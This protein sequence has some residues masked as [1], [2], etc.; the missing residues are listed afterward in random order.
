MAKSRKDYYEENKEKELKRQ[1]E[2]NEKHK[3]SIK[4]YYQINKEELKRKKREYYLKNKEKIISLQ[5]EYNQKNKEH[6][7]EYKK[8]YN[9]AYF[10]NSETST[11]SNDKDYQKNY[12]EKNKERQ[13]EY[14]KIYR[15]NNKEKRN[16]YQRERILTDPLFR[17][18]RNAK[19]AI[20]KAFQTNGYKKESRSFEI[21]GCSFEELKQ[22][23]QDQF[24]SWMNW[25]NYGNPKDGLIEPNKTWDVDHIKP[26]ALATNQE[27]LLELC[28]Y[29]NLQP[30]CSYYNRSVKKDNF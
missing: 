27:E 5:K 7:K 20:S 30:L 13:K 8:E 12:R 18:S 16:L 26:L 1:K 23:L 22:H 10:N 19:R 15:Q 9:K 25:E 3:D 14:Q 4:E 29:T 11:I 21:L 6:I 2:Y 24:E 17:L 28:K